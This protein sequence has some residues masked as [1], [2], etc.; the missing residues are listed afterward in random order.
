ML[1][2]LPA[3]DDTNENT[4]QIWLRPSQIK[5]QYEVSTPSQQILEVVAPTQLTTPFRLTP[6]TLANLHHNKVPRGVF[7][8]LSKDAMQEIYDAF[9]HW[10]GEY[11]IPR[12]YKHISDAGGVLGM[13]LERFNTQTT[14]AR[15]YAS[16]GRKEEECYNVEG[17]QNRSTAWFPD[18]VSG[19]F[20]H[21][22]SSN[23]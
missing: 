23:A 13:R 3:E 10:E 5:I 11:A 7:T 9:T 2:R 12:L 6:E 20:V 21:L 17:I 1:L 22:H 18:P 8:K 15:G 19:I 4:P 16:I 14:R